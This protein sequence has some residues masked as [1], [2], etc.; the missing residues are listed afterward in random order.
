LA[1]TIDD[2]LGIH[3]LLKPDVRDIYLT[4]LPAYDR[5]SAIAVELLSLTGGS[6]DVGEDLQTAR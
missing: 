6:V 5:S 2:E 3:A 4:T 1:P